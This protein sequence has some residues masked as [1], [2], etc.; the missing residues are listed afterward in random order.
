MAATLHDDNE[1][2]TGI[3]ITPM[4]DVML[5]LLIIFMV[6]TSYIV[7]SA[8]D[9]QL[10]QEE[11][12]EVVEKSQAQVT[13][14]LNREGKLFVE[15]KALAWEMLENTLGEMKTAQAHGTKP[16][17][18]LISADKEVSHGLVMN[19][20]DAIRKNGISNFAI[21]VESPAGAAAK[22]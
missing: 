21:N 13:F 2:I 15:G 17:Q 5:V 22:P 1:D 6:T 16:L 18:A 7:T 11:S 10:P 9:M 8:I 4:V 3:N 20:I 14:T 12:G 19:L